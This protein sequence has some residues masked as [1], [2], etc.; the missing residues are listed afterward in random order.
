MKLYSLSSTSIAQLPYNYLNNKLCIL[1]LLQLALCKWLSQYLM[2][3]SNKILVIQFAFSDCNWICWFPVGLRP[4]DNGDSHFST[5]TPNKKNDV[6]LLAT[7]SMAS[8]W[9]KS[10]VYWIRF[11]VVFPDATNGN[12]SSLVSHYLIQNHWILNDYWIKPHSVYEATSAGLC[13]RILL[14]WSA[15]AYPSDQVIWICRTHQ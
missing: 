2:I 12:T 14:G 7:L 8:P 10:I 11:I 15:W 13:G 9:T 4:R 6:F 3:Q 1:H 5:S